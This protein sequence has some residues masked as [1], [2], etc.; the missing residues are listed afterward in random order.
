MKWAPQVDSAVSL[1]SLFSS[2]HISSSSA[3]SLFTSCPVATSMAVNTVPD[4]LWEEGDKRF[5]S[6]QIFTTGPLKFC[7]QNY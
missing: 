7:L 1:F 6:M 4:A 2:L 3:Q 5:T